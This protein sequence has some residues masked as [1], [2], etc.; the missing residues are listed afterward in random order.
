MNFFVPLLMLSMPGVVAVSLHRGQLIR[1]TR[2]N[3]QTLLWEYLLYSFAIVFTVNFVMF[4]SAPHRLVSYAP[5]T[6]WTTSNILQAGF[7]AK[8]SLCAVAAAC[9][10]PQLWQHRREICAWL[11]DKLR[12]WR[13]NL[14]KW[15]INLKE[16]K[17]GED[18]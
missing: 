7:V 11:R 13:T 12:I 10:L 8:Y 5:G 9:G 14:K 16:Y 1:V 15:W 17:I 4:L 2:E 18:E 3:W 6:A